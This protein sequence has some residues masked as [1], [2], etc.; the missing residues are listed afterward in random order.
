MKRHNL[1]FLHKHYAIYKTILFILY[2][3]VMAGCSRLTGLPISRSGIDNDSSTKIID[4]KPYLDAVLQ[5]LDCNVT[6]RCTVLNSPI[7]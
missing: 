3:P 1:A 5:N 7:L 4:K 2:L 6:L